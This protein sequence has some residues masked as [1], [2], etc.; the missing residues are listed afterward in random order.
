MS[1]LREVRAMTPPV[2]I[3]ADE[4]RRLAALEDEHG[5]LGDPGSVGG[6]AQTT[7]RARCCQ[8]GRHD[9]YQAPRVTAGYLSE[10]AHG[11]C[12]CV[13]Y[14]PRQLSEA[15]A[16]ELTQWLSGEPPTCI[17]LTDRCE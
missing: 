11:C 5:A 6:Y 17:A 3:D 10:V 1:A 4:A 14:D 7:K 8:H 16:D 15:E 2:F 12:T 9:L 13:G